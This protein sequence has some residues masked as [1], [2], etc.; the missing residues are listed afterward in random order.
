MLTKI[1]AKGLAL[2]YL[3][4]AVAVAPKSDHALHNRGLLRME[5]GDVEGAMADLRAAI[6]NGENVAAPRC[7]LA[8][9]L[10]K[11]GDA[12]RAL[13]EAERSV[14]EDPQ[15]VY[16]RTVRALLLAANGKLD[17]AAAEAEDLLMR[18]GADARLLL[19]RAELRIADGKVDAALEDLFGA[20]TSARNENA[21]I[22]VGSL[23]LPDADWTRIEAAIGG[24]AGDE[25][26]SVVARTAVAAFRLARGRPAE[27]RTLLEE[28]LAEQ[29]DD[30]GA[31]ELLVQALADLGSYEDA[32]VRLETCAR[33]VQ[34]PGEAR[35]IQL[36]QEQIAPLRK[37]PTR[38]EE[39]LR[40]IDSLI[41]WERFDQIVRECEAGIAELERNLTHATASTV[42]ATRAC[43]LEE[44]RAHWA[45]AV[46]H[47][48]KAIELGALVPSDLT[49]D[50]ILQLLLLELPR[51]Q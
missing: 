17:R 28:A 5:L 26:S 23:E 20:V 41:F 35:V 30:T 32:A 19:L 50:A 29:P 51:P 3:D 49:E 6:A 33:T 22:P 44:H 25:S 46:E 48:K 1:G 36:W 42:L 7:A 16:H 11:K 47:A 4:R 2:E 43:N 45:A 40:R 10:W 12:V 39:S 15:V 8:E 31:M 13:E 38:P 18:D 37:P 24:L 14:H 21:V 9:A 27:A 34:D